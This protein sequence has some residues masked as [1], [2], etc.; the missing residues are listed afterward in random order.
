MLAI[1]RLAH[2][3]GGLL[4]IYA[5]SPWHDT[6]FKLHVDAADGVSGT[7]I[8]GSSGTSIIPY[9][10]L[11]G[12][13][14]SRNGF[15]T[16]AGLDANNNIR[17]AN[18]NPLGSTA[19]SWVDNDNVNM[20]ATVNSTITRSGAFTINA[21]KTTGAGYANLALN[22]SQITLASG[23]LSFYAQSGGWN[24]NGGTNYSYGTGGNASITSGTNE[25]FVYCASTAAGANSI[26]EGVN[27]VD[28]P[29]GPVRLTK[30]NLGGLSF[31]G[32]NTNTWSGGTTVSEGY[33]FL[34]G[35]LTEVAGSGSQ[36]GLVPTSLSTNNLLFLNNTGLLNGQY[37][38]LHANRGIGVIGNVYFSMQYGPLTTNGP[39][40]DGTA[41]LPGH[42]IFDVT[43]NG[44][45]NTP[46]NPNCSWTLG[47]A[48]SYS[49]TTTVNGC[50]LKLAGSDRLPVTTALTLNGA[51][52]SYPPV[53]DLASYNQSVAGLFGGAGAVKGGVTNSAN[54][55]S[56]LTLTGSSDFDGA[57]RDGGAGSGKYLALA[58]YATNKT[59]TL[60]GTA[61]RMVGSAA[62]MVGTL[63]LSSNGLLTA[64]ATTVSPG[65]ALGLTLNTAN[66]AAPRLTV[67]GNLDI[68]GAKL[69]LAGSVPANR[70]TYVLASYSGTLSG[71][72]TTITGLPPNYSVSYGSGSNGQIILR[73]P[74]GGSMVLIQ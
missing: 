52:A 31:Y 42:V 4:N 15:D 44:S 50:S 35:A 9:A 51:N 12:P 37:N 63:N 61:N 21:L 19:L 20:N 25:L 22:N 23:L 67:N 41:K 5:G 6:T 66:A 33:L 60:S 13:G 56:T 53:F 57:L 24:L 58:L 55:T 26:W 54:G 14:V 40:A 74:A 46:S 8:S 62:I 49:G 17:D 68:S 18:W 11:T 2:D 10:L 38:T 34:R 36:L 48:S 71:T 28:N 27:F 43:G 32:S 64:G 47:G 72:F 30:A 39:I 45:G 29:A 70:P 3:V 16:F 65:G 73:P 1:T 59:V 69:A 7:A